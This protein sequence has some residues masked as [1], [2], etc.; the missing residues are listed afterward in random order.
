[1]NKQ[2][3]VDKYAKQA[4]IIVGIVIA[5]LFALIFL[6]GCRNESPKYIFP[7]WE[8]ITPEVLDSLIKND[9]I[10]WYPSPCNPDSLKISPEYHGK[11]GKSEY[12]EYEPNE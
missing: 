12:G 5:L 11:E 8:E 4:M 10:L 1:M 2:Q 9:T 3:Q 7:D 6:G